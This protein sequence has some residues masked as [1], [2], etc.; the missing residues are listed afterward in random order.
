MAKI[1]NSKLD[2]PAAGA[3]KVRVMNAQISP[4]DPGEVLFWN[5]AQREE[6]FRRMYKLFPADRIA[7]GTHVCPLPQGK[8]LTPRWPDASMTLR[9][10]MQTYHLAG[11]MVLQDGQIRLQRYALGFRPSQRWTSFSMAKSF[12]SILLGVALRQGYVHSI[13]DAV[14]TYI[15]ELRV[16]PYA[17]VT[18]RQL[19]TMTSGVRWDENY[20]DPKSD[21]AQVGLGPCHDNQPHALS[22]ATRLLREWPAGTHWNYNTVETDL[23]GILVQRATHRSLATYLSETIWAPYGMESDAYW[24]K[25]ECDGSTIGGS[26]VSATLA[27][28]AR[29]GQFMLDGGCVSG[30]PVIADVWMHDA[31]N[32]LEKTYSP[33][34]GYGYLWWTRSDGS[35]SASGIFGQMIYVDPNRR[36]VIVQVGAWPEAYN[37]A[38]GEARHAFVDAIKHGIDTSH[39]SLENV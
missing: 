37:L 25:D 23:L 14:V 31:L 36:M 26:G 38:L 8:V 6:W 2:C 27:D 33:W 35:Y 16:G 32:V 18:V 24:L 30:K 9:K 17:D 20:A 5:Q 13:D 29:M 19:L 28:Y 7:H 11:V 4:Q 1:K 12:T 10:Y 39:P 21:V 22:Y 3:S 15:P 34:S